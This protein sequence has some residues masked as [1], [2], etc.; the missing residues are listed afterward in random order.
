MSTVRRRRRP[1]KYVMLYC[2]VLMRHTK[3]E[4]IGEPID[5]P[6]GRHQWARCMTTHHVQLVNLDL[7][8]GNGRND[9]AVVPLTP[10]DSK[11]YVPYGEYQ[12][13]DVIYH[14]AW[15]DYGIVRGKEVLSNGLHAIV[16]LFKK[17]KEKRLIERLQQ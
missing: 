9:G 8:E 12:I 16:V 15:D 1:R 13:G 3:H 4:F 6:N 5:T 10:E 2:P 14:P 17:N 7:L 11:R